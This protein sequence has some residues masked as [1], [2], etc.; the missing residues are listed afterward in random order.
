MNIAY[1]ID[2]GRWDPATLYTHDIACAMKRLGHDVTVCIPK[3]DALE[4][5]F[6]SAELNTRRTIHTNLPFF[7]PYILSGMI[8]KEGISI[9]HAKAS[10]EVMMFRAI[11][12][13][14]S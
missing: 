7:N 8:K 9:V 11:W 13:S 4:Q 1:L 14:F 5:F 2:S 3:N 10:S 6:N 12:E